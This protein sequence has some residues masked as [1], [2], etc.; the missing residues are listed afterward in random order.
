[1]IVGCILTGGQSRR[2]GG[3]GKLFLTWEGTPFHE[4]LC[5]ALGRF[6]RIYLSVDREAP[7][8]ALGLPMVRDRYPDCGP[9][10][11]IASVLSACEGEAVFVTACDMPLLSTSVVD[12]IV[13]AWE[14]DITLAC[15][16][17]RAQP[18]LGI[19][20]KSVLPI[21]EKRLATN[22]LRM[23]DF[24]TETG[25]KQVPLPEGCRAAENINTPQ[26][27]RRLTTESGKAQRALSETPSDSG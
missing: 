7:Y 26:D 13:S 23:Y 3:E 2:M 12:R 17:G 11:G 1:M 9:M 14:G 10:G 18:L 24:L 5:R 19:Y 27:Y 8:A 6:S 16:D 21:L 22:R 25:C 15:V 20:P 4:R